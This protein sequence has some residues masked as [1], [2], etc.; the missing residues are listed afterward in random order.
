MDFKY[1][2]SILVLLQR[3]IAFGPINC[4]SVIAIINWAEANDVVNWNGEDPRYDDLRALWRKLRCQH[5]P[6]QNTI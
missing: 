5:M 2:G 1:T 4:Q 6:K 3:L